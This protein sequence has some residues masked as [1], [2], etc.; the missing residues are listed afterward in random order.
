MLVEGLTQRDADLSS[1][2]GKQAAI[3]SETKYTHVYDLETQ[4]YVHEEK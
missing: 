2:L 1:H 3:V 4:V